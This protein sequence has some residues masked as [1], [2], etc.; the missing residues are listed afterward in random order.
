MFK[1]LSQPLIH[2]EIFQERYPTIF[3][4][5]SPRRKSGEGRGG[6]K[7]IKRKTRLNINYVA[8]DF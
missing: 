3:I 4:F 5:T 6:K 2:F 7:R 1:Y 8:V